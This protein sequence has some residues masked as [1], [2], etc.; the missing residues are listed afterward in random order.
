M[1]FH[2][3]GAQSSVR[4]HLAQGPTLQ[5]LWAPFPPPAPCTRVL[6][7]PRCRGTITRRGG[8]SAPPPMPGRGGKLT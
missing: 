6:A 2:L 5:L 3:T 8:D 1:L 7:E 4:G